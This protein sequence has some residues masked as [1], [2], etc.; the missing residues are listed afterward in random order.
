MTTQNQKS[1]LQRL[2]DESWEA[3]L[4]VSAVAIFAILNSFPFLDWMVNKFIENLDPG[5]Y[6]VAYF[7]VVIGYLAVAILA[8]MFSLHFALRAYWIGLVGLNSV[9]PD[10]SLEDSAFSPIYTKKILGILPKL[11]SS[12]TKVDEL[13][14]VIFSAAFALM[15]VYTYLTAFAI[16]YL[17]LYNFLVDTVPSWLLLLPALLIAVVILF[18]SM[19]GIIANLKRYRNSEKLQHLYFLYAKWNGYLLYGPLYKSILMITMIFA[20]NFKK[21]KALIRLVLVMFLFGVAFTLFKMTESNYFYLINPNPIRDTTRAYPEYY[22]N[23]NQEQKFL[24]G[25]EINNNVISNK[26][27]ELFLPIFE[28]ESTRMYADCYP[29]KKEG[30][31]SKE[32]RWK[33]NMACYQQRHEIYIND[34]KVQV[35]FLKTEHYRTGQFG[36]LCYM[37]LSSLA[38]DLHYLKI[39]RTLDESTT[40]EWEI[41]FYNSN[42]QNVEY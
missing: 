14:S 16:T 1:W 30:E 38:S 4:L 29:S 9:F 19:L 2:K 34:T 40:K 42:K 18:G 37:D 10:Y 31:N 33:Q 25:P 22:K 15:L 8:A 12:I 3:E 11:S 23:L 35:K 27:L 28:H 5:Q 17:L 20:S 21:K 41:P 26:T 7:I 36:I 6:N 39:K 13:C 32:K 24:L